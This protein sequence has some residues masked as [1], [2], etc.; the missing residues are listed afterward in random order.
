METMIKGNNNKVTTSINESINKTLKDFQNTLVKTC[1]DMIAKQMS[2][3]NLNMINIIK[4][5]LEGQQIH[6]QILTPDHH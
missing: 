2:I 3:I 1:E 4:D 5:T 6:Q